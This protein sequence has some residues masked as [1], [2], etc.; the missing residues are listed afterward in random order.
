MK[1][2][3]EFIM[4]TYYLF[5]FKFYCNRKIVENIEIRNKFL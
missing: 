5:N 3:D 2:K 4:V 1:F